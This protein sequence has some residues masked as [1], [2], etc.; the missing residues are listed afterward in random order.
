MCSIQEAWGDFQ[1]NTENKV[2]N[3]AKNVKQQQ[4]QIQTERGQVAPGGNPPDIVG[5]V[6]M[7]DDDHR[8]Y[9]RAAKDYHYPDF[10]Q[11]WNKKP[12]TS[13]NGM[14]RGVHN[15]YSRD[16]RIDFKQHSTSIGN[17]ETDVDMK[18]YLQPEEERP[19]YLDIYDK[20]SPNIPSVGPLA[21]LQPMAANADEENYMDVSDN[22]YGKELQKMGDNSFTPEVITDSKLLVEAEEASKTSHSNKDQD[23]IPDEIRRLQE[24]I[25]H[26][27]SKI[28]VL[29]NKVKNVEN[30]TN[31]DIILFV[32][33]A[34]FILFVIDNVFKFNKLS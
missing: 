19:G 5:G 18:H 25:K 13:M 21:R 4:L 7:Q 34:I 3:L 12:D 23:A 10:Q 30:N 26:L 2:S 16:K 6:V 31:H 33:I 32:V 20:P 8:Q 29:E 28:E 14:T 17:L 27:V 9:A 1:P 11:F 24:E 22:F 15:K